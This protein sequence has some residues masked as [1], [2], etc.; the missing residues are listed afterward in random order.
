MKITLSFYSYQNLFIRFTNL[1]SKDKFIENT[2]KTFINRNNIFTF[3][4]TFIFTSTLIF[5]YITSF[6]LAF[7]NNIFK[8]FINFFLKA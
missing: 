6:A 3:I 5:V 4:F 7:I 8:L 1:G 2:Q